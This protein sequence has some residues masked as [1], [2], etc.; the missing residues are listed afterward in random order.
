MKMKPKD[1][2]RNLI[3]E[4]GETSSETR[5]GEIFERMNSLSPDPCWSDHLYHSDEFFDEDE[6][7]DIEAYLNRL[8]EYKPIQL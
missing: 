1:E 3:L 2:M 6:N 8:L 5:T 4:L 7:F